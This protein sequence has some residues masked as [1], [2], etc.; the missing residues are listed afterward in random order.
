[1]QLTAL[2]AIEADRA[3]GA[4][5]EA[6]LRAA[7]HLVE[8]QGQ[9]LTAHAILAVMLEKSQNAETQLER[10][11]NQFVIVCYFEDGLEKRYEME[12]KS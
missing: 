11:A 2:E 12:T 8:Q 7:L 10:E 9:E 4:A 5:C 1:M 3:F 6:A